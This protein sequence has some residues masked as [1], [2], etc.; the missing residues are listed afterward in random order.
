MVFEFV[1]EDTATSATHLEDFDQDGDLD[2]IFETTGGGFEMNEN[3]GGSLV[4]AQSLATSQ[5]QTPSFGEMDFRLEADGK[6]YTNRVF[7]FENDPADYLLQV[8]VKDLENASMSQSFTIELE[9]EVEDLD[10]DG[11]EDHLDSDEDGDGFANLDEVAFGSDPRDHT[12]RPNLSPYD[13]NVS[14]PLMIA[15]NQPIDSD[16]VTIY[17]KDPDSDP[18]TY[19]LVFGEGMKIMKSSSSKMVPCLPLRAWI[20][21]PNPSRPFGCRPR[22]RWVP[23]PRQLCWLK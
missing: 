16:V 14:K 5:S 3:V 19:H 6:L 2:L 12:S 22:I 18:L 23:P 8:L 7:D 17:A 9:N 4:F 21:N 15:E 11:V 20:L 13:L 1:S 10:G